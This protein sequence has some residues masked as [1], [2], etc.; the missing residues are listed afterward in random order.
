MAL[1]F[2]IAYSSSDAGF[3]LDNS[4]AATGVITFCCSAGCMDA[5]SSNFSF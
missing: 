4:W 3:S 1:G 5:D 2:S